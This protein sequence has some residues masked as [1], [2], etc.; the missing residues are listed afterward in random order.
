MRERVLTMLRRQPNTYISGEEISR[1][2]SV[3]RTAIW[4]HIQ[5][6]R[7]DGYE[8]DSHPKLGYALRRTPDR[9]L[10]E[11]IR[12]ELTTKVLGRE[13][14][15]FPEIDSTNNE[16]KKLA[17]AGC[18]EGTIVVADA[19][20][21]GR[22]RLSRGWFSPPCGGIWLSVVLRPPFAPREAP[23]C[24]LMAAVA[25][26]KALR[27]VT[28]LAVGI[29]WPN[30]IMYRGRKM[31]GILTELSAEIDAINFVVLGMGINVNIPAQAFPPELAEVATSPAAEL[32][33]PVP[34]LRLLRQVLAELEENYRLVRQQG[35]DPV[36]TMWRQLSCT[37]GRQVDCFAPDRTFSG[38]AVDIDADGALIVQGDGFI[39][40][41]VAGDVSVRNKAGAD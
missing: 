14:H 18:P 11:E 34:R 32:G 8:I 4:K 25:V 29:K 17:A 35:F 38:V 24:T 40:R 27:E 19:Q 31:V 16:A 23:K 30:D 37:L 39:E 1:A 36:L 13:I 12:W 33:H 3:S 22:G 28:G 7:Q 6:L 10:P 41:V 21:Q 20:Q 15:Y 2:L 5:S 26:A 9:L